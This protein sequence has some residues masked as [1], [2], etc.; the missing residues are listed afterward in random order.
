MI[1]F[2]GIE[3][4][5]TCWSWTTES[6]FVSAQYEIRVTDLCPLCEQNLFRSI[7]IYFTRSGPVCDYNSRL[8]TH[9]VT[10]RTVNIGAKAR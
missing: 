5:L 2:I 4:L 9:L 10:F 8:Y 1:Y 6:V 7:H 3:A